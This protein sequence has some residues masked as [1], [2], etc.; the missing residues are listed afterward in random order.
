MRRLPESWRGQRGTLVREGRGWQ[1][2]G[3]PGACRR[4]QRA[5][6]PGSGTDNQQSSSC[7]RQGKPGGG[8]P[9][10]GGPQV[11]GWGFGHYRVDLSQH[12]SLGKEAGLLRVHDNQIKVGLPGPGLQAAMGSTQH[13]CS[14]WKLTLTALTGPR[15]VATPSLQGASPGSAKPWTGESSPALCPGPRAPW[16]RLRP[17]ENHNG[18]QIPFKRRLQRPELEVWASRA[19]HMPRGPATPDG[20]ALLTIRPPG[21]TM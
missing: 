14:V 1:P 2:Q 9:S 21:D 20:R 18:S 5:R 7:Q 11:T 16:A 13:T 12:C 17:D 19:P 3:Y 6:F 15:R 8:A 10:P 4:Q